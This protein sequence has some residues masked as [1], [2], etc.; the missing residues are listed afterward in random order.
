MDTNCSSVDHEDSIVKD[1]RKK[2][3][4]VITVSSILML[5]FGTFYFYPCG[6][7]RTTG[8]E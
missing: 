5:F 8:G 6:I 1:S 2:R 7:I 3:L 4:P